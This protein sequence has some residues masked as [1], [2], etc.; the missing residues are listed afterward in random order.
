VTYTYALLEVSAAA[1]DEIA[2]KLREAGYGQAFNSDGEIDMHGIAL[3]RTSELSEHT[4][5][6]CHKRF[7]GADDRF[8]PDC[9]REAQAHG[10]LGASA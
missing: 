7:R 1:Y 9:H 6:T 3:A 2:A 10:P 8:C 5:P 4:C